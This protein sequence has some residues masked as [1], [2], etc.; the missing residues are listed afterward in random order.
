MPKR[1]RSTHPGSRQGAQP[2]KRQRRG[3]RAATTNQLAQYTGDTAFKPFGGTRSSRTSADYLDAFKT[4]HAPLPR[5]V[6]GYAVV[7]TTQ[8]I[9]STAPFIVLGPA[10]VRGDPVP[11][12]QW[13]NI[14]AISY[15]LETSALDGAG[16]SYLHVFDAMNDPSWG[17]SRCTPSAFSVQVMN[18][19]ALQTTNGIAYIGRVKQRLDLGGSTRTAGEMANHLVSYSNPRLCSAGKLA[20]AGVQVDS[21]PFD[22][23]SLADF[24]TLS[25]TV[26]G[27]STWSSGYFDFDGFA[28]TFVYNPDGIELQFLVC[29]EWRTRFDPS[30]PAYAT[31]V[32][33][34]PS[35]E[36]FWSGL[37]RNAVALGN[38]VID[39]A[40]K[41]T[42]MLPSVQALRRAGPAAQQLMLAGA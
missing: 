4:P 23:N 8:V 15:E 6:G 20:L 22:M 28:P 9:T 34:Q 7:R 2:R 25:Q 41:A 18:G 26:A 32:Y 11:N 35:T 14:C 12:R 16:E 30:N 5:A 42:P 27:A 39:I 10:A 36:H 1:K 13:S 24:R 21:I 29:C 31:H 38:G 19:T 33:H 3:R 37:V 17:H 40:Q